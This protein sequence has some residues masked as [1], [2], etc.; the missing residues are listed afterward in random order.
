M[1]PRRFIVLLYVVLLSGF[2]IG[3]GALF[4]D[5]RAEYKALQRTHEANQARLEAAEARLREQ[6]R[7]L[8]RLKNDPSFMERVLRD[9]LHYAKPDEVI[10]RFEN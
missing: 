10:F 5:A 7:V 6:Q 4:V 9:R 3:A 2:G 8:E 1:T